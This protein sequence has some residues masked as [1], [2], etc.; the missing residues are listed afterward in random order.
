MSEEIGK[1]IKVEPEKITL[2]IPTTEGCGLCKGKESCTFHGPSSA[3]R[4][5]TLPGQAGFSVGDYVTIKT[6][7]LARNL[8]ALIIFVLPIP[9][10]IGGYLIAEHYFH[11]PLSELWGVLSGFSIYGLLLFI[12]NRMLSQ[13]PK[14]TPTISKMENFYSKNP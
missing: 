14:F 4:E 1:I 5:M 9:L 13:L 2:I 6:S 12:A 10:L 3:Y 11:L 8:S 7:E